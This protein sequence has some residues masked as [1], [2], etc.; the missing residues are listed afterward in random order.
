MKKIIM[1]CVAITMWAGAF[2]AD[3][4]TLS[5][6]P[7]RT[8]AGARNV[9]LTV[10]MSNTN[11]VSDL[12]FD[13][14]LPTGVSVATGS[15]GSGRISLSS[16][17][18]GANAHS[19]TTRTQSDGSVRVVCTSQSATAFTGNSGAV[20]SISLNIDA[21]IAIGDKTIQLKNIV[22]S[23]R[24][25]SYTPKAVKGTLTVQAVAV[26]TFM[27]DGQQLSCDTLVAGTPITVPTVAGREG[28]T[29]SGWGEVPS[30]MPNYDLTLTATFLI[31]HYAILFVADGKEVSRDTLDYHS[32]ITTPT[33]PHKEGYTF[34]GWGNVDA[35]VPAH[36]CT[37]TAQYSPN[38]YV[39]T[40]V[41]DSDIVRR[42]SVVY[43]TTVSSGLIPQAPAKEG[44]SFVRWDSL[45]ATMPAHDVECVAVYEINSYVI[46]FVA[47]G[48]EV[49]SD[50]LA[51]GFAITAPAAPQKEGYTFVG[52]GDV[53]ATVP[54]H[55]CTYTAQY[56]VNNYILSFIADGQSIKSDTIAYGSDITSA[57]L[58]QA[59]AKE[60][61]TF[62]RWDSLPAI[63][64]AHD[65]ECMA[66]Y[67]LNKYQISFLM[68][69]AVYETDSLCYGDTIILPTDPEKEGYTFAGWQ[70]QLT[71]STAAP[72][73]IGEGYVMPPA[74]VVAVA[75]FTQNAIHG[76]VNGDDT[77]NSSDAVAVYN[78][79]SSGAAAGD[80]NK[81]D[82]NNDGV[83]N[84]TDVV[85]VFNVIAAGD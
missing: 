79:I 32:A 57:V 33:A 74:D 6:S 9:E 28:Y 19:V 35:T 17:R 8:V 5:I 34:V 56:S 42:D 16:G 70:E 10:N 36:D 12:Q 41:A 37:Y 49:K 51:Y 15:N 30:V 67:S 53:A 47:N 76:D 62:L 63:M 52:W 11:S 31:N 7:V 65:V 64:P 48:L 25:G 80:V 14:V 38:T 54:A 59:P 20:L 77:V 61:Y 18:D 3:N 75:V 4:N 39:L 45:P 71:D 26:L 13:L 55:D 22:L 66:V 24:N 50:T 23:D 43:T 84:S 81:A 82:L 83:V 44:Y 72:V 78:V 69:D 60:G 2:A 73:W 21:N 58:P 68:D 40:F 27:L 1:M 46:S 29:F 85:E